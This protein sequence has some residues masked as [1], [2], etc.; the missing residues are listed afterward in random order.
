MEPELVGM[1]MLIPD[2]IGDE[3]ALVEDSDIM[4][5][6]EPIFEVGDGYGEMV[7]LITPDPDVGIT[8]E[9]APLDIVRLETCPT[10]S[11]PDVDEPVMVDISGMLSDI[12]DMLLIM[13]DKLLETLLATLEA[14]L[15]AL[16][17]MLVGLLL[18]ITDSIGM[19]DES[20][21][22]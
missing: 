8:L 6:P 20:V 1:D 16:D 5:L 9:D 13:D 2:D 12:S 4:L 21:E 15:E 10:D 11:E 14:L 19:L 17:D 3:E 7:M 18:P 22:S